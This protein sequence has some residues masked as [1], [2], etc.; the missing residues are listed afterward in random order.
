MR[1]FI[2]VA[3]FIMLGLI[4]YFR[5]QSVSYKEQCAWVGGILLGYCIAYFIGWL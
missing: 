3:F 2:L 4:G 5:G 1:F